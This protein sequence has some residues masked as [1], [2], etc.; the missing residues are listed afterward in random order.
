MFVFS[1]TRNKS[2]T[3]RIGLGLLTGE[4]ERERVYETSFG[5]VGRV[6][7]WGCC[8][9]SGP[10]RVVGT[11]NDVILGVFCPK[12]MLFWFKNVL[13]Q[14]DVVLGPCTAGTPNPKG[15]S[16]RGKLSVDKYEKFE[17]RRD[18]GI[19]GSCAV[20]TVDRIYRLARG[21]IESRNFDII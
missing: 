5:L 20:S 10:Y 9:G 2:I 1:Y 13:L 11:Q 17:C 3:I 7:S 6:G 16:P 4:E 18:Y 21:R 19:S 8:G 12:T 14:N 15:C